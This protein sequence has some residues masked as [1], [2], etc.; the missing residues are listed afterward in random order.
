MKHHLVPIVALYFA[1][2]TCG[3]SQTNPG[4]SVSVNGSRQVIAYQGWPILVRAVV[5]HP[6]QFGHNLTPLDVVHGDYGWSSAVNLGLVDSKNNNVIWNFQATTTPEPTLH[7]DGQHMGTLIWRIS[8]DDSAAIPEGNYTLNAVLDNTD[9]PLQTWQGVVAAVAVSIQVKS[10][11]GTLSPDDD[12]AHAQLLANYYALSG[13]TA[14][15]L[16]A[17]DDLF[18]R[19]PDDLGGL[20]LRGALLQLQGS[21]SDAFAAYAQAFHVFQTQ[22]P[23]SPEPPKLLLQQLG[24]LKIKLQIP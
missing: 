11:P 23:N 21:N 8:P 4:I 3:E 24:L 22:F 15:G 10:A 7:L 19:Q 14:S 17:L 13:D 12:S 6:L 18:S 20:S 5:L 16:A 9:I 2:L 1:G